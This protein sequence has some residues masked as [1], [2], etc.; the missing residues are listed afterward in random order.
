LDAPNL[1]ALERW[2]EG[3]QEDRHRGSG[4]QIV[5]AMLGHASAITAIGIRNHK[6]PE[7]KK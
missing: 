3:A 4:A 6:L 2:Q 5:S 1:P 7:L